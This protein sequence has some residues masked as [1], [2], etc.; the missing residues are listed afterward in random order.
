MKN[1]LTRFKPLRSLTAMGARRHGQGGGGTSSPPGDV[2][3]CFY[4][5]VVTVKGSV[6]ELFMHYFHNLSS[7]SGSL[8]PTPAPGL[9]PWTLLGD[10]RPQTH[11][12]PTPGKNPAGAHADGLLPISQYL[13]DKV[14]EDCANVREKFREEISSHFCCNFLVVRL[15]SMHPIYV[16]VYFGFRF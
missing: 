13:Y 6:D 5:L 1:F 11:S 8:A 9:L 4:K 2:V 14:D 15:L 12:L 10:F 16:C 7:A 3:Q